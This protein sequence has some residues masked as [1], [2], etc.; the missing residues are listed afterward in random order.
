MPRQRIPH[1]TISTIVRDFPANF[2]QRLKRFQRESG[3]TWAELGRRL[4]VDRETI[5]RWRDR[6]VVPCT[7][8]YVALLAVA[9][10]FGLGHLFR[11]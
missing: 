10:S 5:R 6:G 11:D 2:S 4:G 8:N 1:N 9:D 7:R 3:I